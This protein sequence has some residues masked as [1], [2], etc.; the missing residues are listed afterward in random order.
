MWLAHQRQGF[1]G[2]T[3]GEAL[4]QPRWFRRIDINRACA[5]VADVLDAFW[6]A[7]QWEGA[8]PYSGGVLDAWPARMADGLA[9]ARQEW[10][11]VQAFR[12]YEANAARKDVKHG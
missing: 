1:F 8:P 11:T 5:H 2:W 6:A 10:A 12:R 4:P 9:V 3:L 7:A